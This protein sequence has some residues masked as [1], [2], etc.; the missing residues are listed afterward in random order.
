MLAIVVGQTLPL[1]TRLLLVGAA[2]D[3]VRTAVLG[4]SMSKPLTD[5]GSTH[6]KRF[7]RS[8]SELNQPCDKFAPPIT[9]GHTHNRTQHPDA[10][11]LNLVFSLGKCHS[12][13]RSSV[14]IV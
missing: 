2:A 1:T 12:R 9:G 11:S 6:T 14:K 10:L 4:P 13:E 3:T 8:V 5:G 7:S